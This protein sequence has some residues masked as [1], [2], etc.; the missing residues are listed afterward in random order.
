MS[1]R[2]PID[3]ALINPKLLG[4]ALGDPTP[5][6]AWLAV[7]KAA[8]ALPLD[9]NE[10]T[11]FAAV[12]G[13]RAP[14]THRV[15]ELWAIV[16]RRGGKS[17]M[18]AALAVYQ[19]CFTK[20]RLAAGEVG[21]VLVLATNRDQAAVVFNYAL[22]FL[23]SSPVLAKEVDSTTAHEIR[24][25][26]GIVI[27]VHAN[28]F[29]SVRGR[30]LVACIFDETAFWRDDTSASPDVEVYRAVLPS[31][32]TTKG[33]LVSISTPYR[34][35]G[36]LHQKHREHFG[37]D[38]DGVLVVQG[39]ST[40]FNPELSEAA[41]AQALADDREG[42][43]SEYEAEFRSDLAT[44]LD[45]E[46]VEAAVDY[47]RPLELPPRQGIRHF[48]FVDP[49]GGRGD[50][51]TLC[52]GH[53][54]KQGDRF[55][56][57]VVRGVRPPFDPVEVTKSYAELC[58]EYKIRAVHGDNY[59]AEWAVSAFKD[60]GL[61]Y[62]LSDKP[63]SQ[64]Y[65]EAL[66]LFTRQAISI[67]DHTQLLRELRLLER[68]THRSGKDSVDH[69]RRGSDDYANVLCGCA[70]FAVRRGGYDSSMSWV[71]ETDGVRDDEVDTFTR[72]R[73]HQHIARYAGWR[74]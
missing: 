20:H 63:K 38:D 16:G 60:A 40:R 74:R 10:R 26:N 12:S 67:P 73:L 27:A 52:I 71:S 36:L 41:I 54:E 50:A 37:M 28:S 43:R 49:S 42:N 33:L 35:M 72:M 47:G 45:D 25:K 13:E 64:L 61:R 24:L 68:Q 2:C 18:A 5:W 30:T 21:T 15:R 1:A 57:D 19:A 69:G 66:P 65:L 7:L 9:K 29:R 4:A 34:R 56:A 6:A 48:A 62:I 31:L 11:T 46:L 55:V 39:P 44:F 23:K 58:K 70:T 17:R 3:K 22:A 14:P 53:K 8:F 32:L 59:S 51:Y